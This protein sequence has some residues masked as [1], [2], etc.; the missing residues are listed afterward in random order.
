MDM[1]INYL[2]GRNPK[3]I[4]SFM[5]HSTKHSTDTLSFR[6]Y[7]WKKPQKPHDEMSN[8]GARQNRGHLNPRYDLYLRMAHWQ[9]D[10]KLSPWADPTC[11]L[12]GREP[13]V[14]CD[15][16]THFLALSFWMWKFSRLVRHT[17]TYAFLLG[18][19]SA[20]LIKWRNLF[21]VQ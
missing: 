2:L 12:L 10:T 5:E 4:I 7:G 14:Q 11:T 15:I 17:A 6:F 3:I 20:C 16:Y 1:R 18:S 19:L 21:L 8:D 9:W 13:R